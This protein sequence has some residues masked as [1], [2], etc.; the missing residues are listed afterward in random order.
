MPNKKFAGGEYFY[1]PLK[2]LSKKT[3]SLESYII[4]R[5]PDRNFI[6]TNGGN[7]S[8]QLICNVSQ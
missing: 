1:G 6:F 8:L 2:L 3:F 4:E 5:F 7:F